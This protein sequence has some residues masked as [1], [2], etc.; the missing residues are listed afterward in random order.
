MLNRLFVIV[1]LLVILAI[2]AA[3]VIPRLI[4]WSDYRGRLESMA[5]E[6]F[7]AEVAIA[8]DIQLTL[9]PQPLLVFTDV[10]VGPAAQPAMQVG[11]VEAEFSL[12]DFLSDRYRVTRLRLERPEV[13]VAIAADG[14]FSSGIALAAGAEQSNVSI[15]NADVRDGILR[16]ADARSGEVHAAEAIAGELRLEALQGPFS[17][18]GRATLDGRP[19]ALRVSTGRSDGAGST[20][21]SYYVQP[22]DQSFVLE[23][24]GT[25]VATATPSFKGDLRY[26]Q[27]PRR[28]PDGELADAGRGDLVLEGKVEATGER[29]L[30]TNYTLLPDD[31]RAATR[32]TGAAELKLGQGMAFNAV[33]SGGIVALPPRDAT[34]ELTDPPYELVRLLDEIALPPIPPVPGTLGL[35]IAEVNL[36]GV[37]LRDLRLDAR[38]DASK[39]VIEDF[40]ASLPGATTLGLAGELS[41]I[42]GEPVFS[43]AASI[44]SKQ[45][46]RLAALWRKPADSNPLFN[47]PGALHADIALSADTLRL[48]SGTLLV[49][50]INQD[51]AAT[52]GFGPSRD[53]DLELHF[54]TLG[55]V[56]SAAVAALL[57]DVAGNGSFGATF[58]KGHLSVSASRAV[59]FGIA[60]SGL[61]ADARWEGGVLELSRLAAESLGGAGFEARLTAFG[62]LLK[63]EV[64]GSGTLEIA[65]GAP[66][67]ADL[68][69]R[70]A[71]PPAVSEFLHRSLPADVTFQLGAPAGDG[72]QALHIEGK[73]ATSTVALDARLSAG[74]ANALVAPIAATLDLRSTSSTL[75]SV[76]L[77]LGDIPI[78]DTR[79][80]LHLTA[81]I[82]GQPA[83]SYD[84]EARLEGGGDHVAF[85]GAVVPGDF[86]HIAGA[87]TIDLALGDPAALAR[88]LGAEGIYVPPLQGTAMLNFSGDGALGVAD[89]EAGGVTGALDWARRDGHGVL[90]GTLRI[91][92]L[93]VAG[94]A[95]LLAGAS[96]ALMGEGAWPDG[97]IDI[98]M[99]PRDGTGRIDIEAAA[100]TAGGAPLLEGAS[101][102]FDWDG[103]SVTLRNLRGMLGAGSVSLSAT[104]CCS[105]GLAPEKQLTGRVALTDVALDRLFPGA[106][107]GAL[108]GVL[109]ASAAFDGTGATIAEA[110]AAMTGSGSY[111]ISGFSAAALNPQVFN[112]AAAL[113][114]VLDM[115]PEALGQGVTESLRA[116]PFE[117][118][119]FSG[120]FTVAGGVLR[121][122]NLAIAGNGARLFGSG[123]L[124]LPDLALSARYAM[125]P[126]VLA[127]PAGAVD[128]NSAEVTALVSGPLWAP[129]VRYDVSTLVDGMM[130]RASEIELARLEEL[131]LEDERR[132]QELAADRAR[133]AA[134]Q[135]AAD[136]AR[137]AAEEEAARKAAEAEAA[138]KAAAEAARLAEEEAARR[139]AEEAERRR[140]GDALARPAPRPPAPVP[141]DLGLTP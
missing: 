119:A 66:L 34:K 16:V 140:L 6:A 33:V 23:G 21:L 137:K 40:A 118:G 14:T 122:P 8:G 87:G 89:I 28:Q 94:L 97:P 42:D 52:I 101:F 61:V 19:Y 62:T 112:G 109:T 110:V 50:G 78:F 105:T 124:A 141:M 26:R 136:A 85:D 129:Q 18:Q 139:A 125:T 70:I 99:T 123:T 59:L 75:M 31:N 133:V 29:I 24:A 53:L 103:R 111:T 102:G 64:S 38:T 90:T 3:F 91:P 84:V 12:F 114:G 71:T 5:T 132:Q 86:T 117:S 68:L 17:F 73:L 95:P 20:S 77:G 9:L 80:P 44:E 7:G 127:N 108:D 98:G 22:E 43:G 72:G 82:A 130:I 74:I 41:E 57:P 65:D 35:D 30:F 113:S 106:L 32:L 60:G 37:A 81:S 116:A 134:E 138:R 120:S 54:T 131:R 15:A 36:R 76:Q 83:D 13:T 47:M 88:W 51:F 104:A 58:P 55:E 1:G 67:V 92:E 11:R 46:D 10:R 128:P 135:A 100:I 69:D 27:P 49:A 63:P 126:T 115:T 25:L 45:L 96:G 39:W 48:S 2:S 56:E 93:D 107:A 121:S 4:Q 79:Q